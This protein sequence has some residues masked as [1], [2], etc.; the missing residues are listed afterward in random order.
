[1]LAGLSPMVACGHRVEISAS[2]G[3]APVDAVADYETLLRHADLAL[4]DAK[5][6]GRSTWRSSW[7]S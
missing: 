6:G 2:I 7:R 5:K 4:Y 3:I 1:V